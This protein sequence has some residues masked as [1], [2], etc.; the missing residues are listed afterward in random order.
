[1]A[2]IRLCDTY[3]R[4]SSSPIDV[5]PRRGQIVFLGLYMNQN[6]N[7]HQMFHH[8]GSSIGSETALAALNSQR[9]SWIERE[10]PYV[11]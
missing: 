3:R 6:S 10:D 4:Y 11:A 8:R 7:I 9:V 5:M 1:M 2:L